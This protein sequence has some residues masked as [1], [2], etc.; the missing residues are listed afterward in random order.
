MQS[1][2][3]AQTGLKPTKYRCYL[4]FYDLTGI[5]GRMLG[6]LV[7][8]T[9]FSNITHVGPIIETHTQGELCIT[10]C[11]GRV[12]GNRRES[13]AKVHTSATFEKLGAVLVRKIPLGEVDLNL[14]QV[15]LEAKTYTDASAWDLIFHLFIGQFLGLTR[16]RSCTTFVCRLFGLP[17][18]WHP[19]RLWRLYDND[20][21]GRTGQGR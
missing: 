18:V 5:Q 10:I 2:R 4:G 1:I 16:P 20:S 17:D 21:S 7:K 11:A 13:V 6:G 19:A 15:V 8:V 14:D 12:V 9:G 3:S